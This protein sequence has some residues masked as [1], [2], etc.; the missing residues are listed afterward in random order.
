M[1]ILRGIYLKKIFII[2]FIIIAAYLYKY[3]YFDHSFISDRFYL[4]SLNKEKIELAPG[5][6]FR[7]KIRYINIRCSFKSSNSR[8]AAVDSFGTVHAVSPGRAIIY[9]KVKGHKDF[10]CYIKVKKRTA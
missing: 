5:E 8:V 10:K 3:V 9:V 1:I 2:I 6:S 4:Y 7:I